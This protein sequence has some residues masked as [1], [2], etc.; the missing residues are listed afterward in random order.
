[1]L[2]IIAGLSGSGKS[3]ALRALADL[4][5]YTVENYPITLKDELINLIEKNPAYNKAAVI[6]DSLEGVTEIKEVFKTDNTFI[7][8]LDTNNE[9]I[10]KRYSET[11][12]PHPRYESE[13]D[14]SLIETIIRERNL[15]QEIKESANLVI[16]TSNFN[17]YDLRLRIKEV[18]S[19][20]VPQKALS[21]RVN[22]LTFGYKYGIPFTSDMILDVRFLKNPYY[23]PE[24]KELT[25]RDPRVQ[26]YVFSDSKAK[27]YIKHTVDY[28]EHCINNFISDGRAYLNIGIGC[29]GGKHRS[30]SVA[31]EL[32]KLLE[33][34]GFFTSV[35][36][37]DN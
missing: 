35:Q 6:F 22:F 9:S 34:K 31:T 32:A 36:H 29:S 4:G 12:R 20:D 14:Q 5:F 27:E 17:S 33:N 26:D 11:R 16:D 13:M 15:M 21:L 2:V 10:L 3:T 7:V 8:Y 1:M 30:I 24:L 37:R 28:L 23:I 19:S 25:G 18:F